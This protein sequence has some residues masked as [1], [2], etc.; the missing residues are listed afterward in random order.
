MTKQHL[1][2]DPK[3]RQERALE[4]IDW[5]LMFL[6]DEI[7]STT[8]ILSKFIGVSISATLATLYK[9]EKKQLIRRG[10]IQFLGSRA[11][12]LWGITIDGLLEYVEPKNIA[13]MK[14]RTFTPGRV[15]L[16]TI[17]HTLMIQ[18]C[19]I[20]LEDEKDFDNWVPTRL[21]PGQNEKKTSSKHWSLY[22]DGIIEAP[23][24]DSESGL[25]VALEVELTR[26]TPQR[27]VDLIKN[28]IKN[29]EKNRY[30]HVL[31]F[32]PDE[33]KSKSLEA[34]FNR[35]ISDK[36]IAYWVD[37]DEDDLSASLERTRN[38]FRFWS[39]ESIS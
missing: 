19:R 37:V 33:K 26:K 6:S 28:H 1:I 10:S 18:R 36:K 11:T 27:Y 38:I 7:Y 13:T 9:M 4:K 8:A 23:I 2:S 17:E 20:F 30:K 12:T 31:Y 32:S 15:S 34:L 39:L 25:P 3:E 16:R 5:V 29:I 35:L 22:P 21:L 24:K 14:F